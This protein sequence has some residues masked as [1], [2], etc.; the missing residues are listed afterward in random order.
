MRLVRA[1]ATIDRRSGRPCDGWRGEDAGDA[2]ATIDPGPKKVYQT[3]PPIPR[4]TPLIP[5]P[6]AR[7][8]NPYPVFAEVVAPENLRWNFAGN[9]FSRRAR[10]N[11]RR[12]W[13]LK[14]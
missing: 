10:E 13:D 7:A 1:V 6:L 11:W 8:E 14:L 3:P 9:R 5:P 4:D 2:G 12:M